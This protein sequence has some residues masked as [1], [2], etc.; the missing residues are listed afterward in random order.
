[1]QTIDLYSN[2]YIGELAIELKEKSNNIIIFKVLLS[3]FQFDEILTLI[4]LGQYNSE[5]VI[6]KFFNCDG[7]YDEDWQCIRKQEFYD[8]LSSIQPFVSSGLTDVYNAIKAIVLSSIQNNN[9]LF[10]EMI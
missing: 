10:I 4:P 7:W 1:M 2:S 6:S 8:Q 3:K 5:S 9:R